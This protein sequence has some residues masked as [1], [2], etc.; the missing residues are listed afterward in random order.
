MEPEAIRATETFSEL[1]AAGP[2][3][4]TVRSSSSGD[5]A[6]L[7]I[8]FYSGGVTDAEATL[9]ALSAARAA[10]V[11]RGG[12]LV[13]DAAPLAIRARCDAWGPPPKAF[14]LMLELKKRFDPD[15]RLNPGRFVGGI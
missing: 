9:G 14:E 12:A 2:L 6:T 10:A 5:H 8:G 15:R 4:L 1:C 3:T 11:E 13:I 7:G